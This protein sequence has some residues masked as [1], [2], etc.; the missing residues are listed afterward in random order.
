MNPVTRQ[1]LAKHAHVYACPVCAASMAL[2]GEKG[3]RLAC[4]ANHSFDIAREGYVNLLLPGSSRSKRPGHTR[5]MLEARRTLFERGF[6]KPLLDTMEPELGAH[7]LAGDGTQPARVLDAGCGEGTVPSILRVGG[8]LP[9]AQFFGVDIAK[10][11]IRAAAKLDPRI[12]WSVTN[13]QRSLPFQSSSFSLLLNVLAPENAGEFHRVLAPGGV[14]LK[15]TSMPEHLIEFREAIYETPRDTRIDDAKAVEVLAPRFALH[16]RQRL[17]YTVPM[18]LKS[19]TALLDAS[20]LT[21]KGKRAKVKA[22]RSR[23]LTSVTVD[24]SVLRLVRHGESPAQLQ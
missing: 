23:G 20:P 6:F 5:E 11:G 7:T 1:L 3:A 19:T 13:V 4:P 2:G 14:L 17:T 10:D 8:V 18:D 16:D 21:W 24:L 9:R 15:V 22:L 12:L